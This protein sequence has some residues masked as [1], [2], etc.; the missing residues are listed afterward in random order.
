VNLKVEFAA[1]AKEFL[2]LRKG[3]DVGADITSTF[4]G[5]VNS[6]AD[7][8][9][10]ERLKDILVYV[11]TVEAIEKHW[12]KV[13]DRFRNL[14]DHF[15]RGSSQKRH[16]LDLRI[17]CS[18]TDDTE[19]ARP[20]FEE[21]GYHVR[22]YRDDRQAGRH[23]FYVCEA[24]CRLFHRTPGRRFVGLL[25]DDAMTIATAKNTFEAE[26]ESAKTPDS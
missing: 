4:L 2:W 15:T 9:L 25:T 5:M 14:K 6:L 26:W 23:R 17:L 13:R 20:V 24:R 11:K 1:E 10:A 8:E 21:Q 12:P 7:L 3:E 18:P 16:P 22:H 19:A